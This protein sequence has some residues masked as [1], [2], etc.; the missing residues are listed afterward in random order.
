[1]KSTDSSS[2]FGRG[3]QCKI[4]RLFLSFVVSQS[5]S[6]LLLL[7]T[8]GVFWKYSLM[9]EESVSSCKHQPF[10]QT[11]WRFSK[12]LPSFLVHILRVGYWLSRPPRNNLE[13]S[14][15]K[16]K[17]EKKK[18]IH[19]GYQPGR[20]NGLLATLNMILMLLSPYTA[21]KLIFNSLTISVRRYARS[22]AGIVLLSLLFWFF[23]SLL[24]L[25]SNV[26]S[27]YYHSWYLVSEFTFTATYF[28]RII[29]I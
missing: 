12:I 13:S 26:S 10:C 2:Y 3:I 28:H 5:V 27:T 9:S 8:L 17:K 18:P 7:L 16:K 4:S 22:C 24:T 25:N 6:R 11:F 21:Q 14:H 29:D 23:I 19:Q 20:K 1:M 15:D